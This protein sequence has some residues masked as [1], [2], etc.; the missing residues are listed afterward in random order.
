MT[1]AEFEQTPR[2]RAFQA[3]CRSVDN[4]AQARI[5]QEAVAQTTGEEKAFWLRFQEGQRWVTK[6]FHPTDAVMGWVE[7]HHMLANAGNDAGM[8]RDLIIRAVGLYFMTER[9]DLWAAL[10]PELRPHLRLINHSWA[11]CHHLGHLRL[12]QRRWRA[13]YVTTNRAMARVQAKYPDRYGDSVTW[14][15]MLTLRAVA[16]TAMGW[17]GVAEKDVELATALE[18]RLDRRLM[19]PYGLALAQSELAFAQGR[20]QGARAALQEGMA[21]STTSQHKPHPYQQVDFDLL[22]ARI[23]RAEGRM[24]S[25]QHFCEQA[26]NRCLEWGLQLSEARVRAIMAGAER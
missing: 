7:L 10:F 8:Y 4:A 20:F 24:A 26:L 3:A 19:E 15:H 13:A 16:A 14:I 22:A 9:R 21:R 5:I 12:R 11:F 25:F 1:Q 23:A 2:Y 6:Y 17:L 18:A